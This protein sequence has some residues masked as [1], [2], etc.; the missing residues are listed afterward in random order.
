MRYQVRDKSEQGESGFELSEFQV[1]RER[2]R[3]RIAILAV[4]GWLVLVLVAT[5]SVV[6]AGY[7]RDLYW[8]LSVVTQPAGMAVCWYLSR[9]RIETDNAHSTRAS[10]GLHG[11]PC[12][13]E[14]KDRGK[15]IR[16]SDKERI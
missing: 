3:G 10:T 4:A 14:G 2:N 8:I 9:E 11:A 5:I 1:I 16:R 12:L 7:I 6:A 15:F 13:F